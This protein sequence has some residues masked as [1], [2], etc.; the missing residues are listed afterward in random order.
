MLVLSRKPHERILIPAINACIH[1]AATHPGV[2]RVAINAPPDVAILRGELVDRAAE[3]GAPVAPPPAPT[4]S[5]R[6]PRKCR[7]MRKRLRLA[8]MA[9]GLARLQLRAGWNTEA[10][11][12]LGRVHRQLDA[13]R[14][15]LH[16]RAG[17]L[18]STPPVE[19][20]PA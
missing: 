10:A 5:P 4:S 9:L 7:Q 3:W 12:A 15:H 1:V 14:R 16:R 2:V 11:A 17:R 13:L 8:S 18:D 19:A 6:S 20:L